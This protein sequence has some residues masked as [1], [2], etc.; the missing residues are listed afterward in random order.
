M[1]LSNLFDT[2]F[3]GGRDHR[4]RVSASLLPHFEGALVVT[5]L[6]CSSASLQ[7]STPAARVHQSAPTWVSAGSACTIWLVHRCVPA[8]QPL[9]AKMVCFGQGA[10]CNIA[11]VFYR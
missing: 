6:C 2:F 3:E 7:V 9:I 10:S 4:E 1:H 11:L 8:T 5:T